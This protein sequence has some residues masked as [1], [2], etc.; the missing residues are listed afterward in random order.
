MGDVSYEWNGDFFLFNLIWTIHLSKPCRDNNPEK[1][2]MRGSK[3]SYRS[4]YFMVDLDGV[5]GNSMS[6]FSE[7]F[8]DVN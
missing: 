3:T 4:G 2:G 7:R 5:I 6:A 1:R 8:S